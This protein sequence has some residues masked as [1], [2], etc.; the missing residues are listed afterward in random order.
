[1]IKNNEKA[2][3]TEKLE[4]NYLKTCLCKNNHINCLT[5]KEWIRNQVAIWEL[6]YEKRDIRDKDVHPAS[7]PI[8]L[9]KRCIELFTHQGE[10][11]IDPFVGIGSTL[12]AAKDT[13]RNAVGFDLNQAYVEYTK[14]RLED[15]ASL[16]FYNTKQIVICDNATN[17]PNY[18]ENNTV[19]LSVTSP[20]YANLLNRE[21]L[22]KTSR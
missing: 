7:Y 13:G 11:V 22:N 9:P 14:K 19:S 16:N 2:E 4:I 10:L 12:L 1:M 17:I 3:K 6:Y 8:S 18:L 15:N 5:G 21:R 20:P